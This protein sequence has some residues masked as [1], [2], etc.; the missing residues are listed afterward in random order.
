[1]MELDLTKL[2]HQEL[3]DLQKAIRL[4]IQDTAVHKQ[5]IGAYGKLAVHITEDSDKTWLDNLQLIDKDISY[6]EA[7][8]WFRVMEKSIFT[9]CDVALNN[10]RVTQYTG[11]PYKI[12][13]RGG[14]S[15]P[16]EISKD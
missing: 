14:Q 3:L 12:F 6:G 16:T 7:S 8:K 5:D 10:M 11:R 15:I 13:E 9:M 1:M 4:Q 2:S